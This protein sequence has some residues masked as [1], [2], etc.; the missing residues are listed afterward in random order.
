MNKKQDIKKIYKNI[1]NNKYFYLA[2]IF[3]FILLFNILTPYLYDDFW[4]MYGLKNDNRI[5]NLYDIF[6]NLKTMYLEW[7][8][9]V[10]AHFFAYFFLMLPKWI[11]NIINSLVYTLNIYLI[12][13]IAKGKRKD[14]YL[15]LFLI[16]MLI[17]VFFPVFGQIFLWL[18]GSCNYSFTLCIQLF[19]I[20]KILNIKDNKYNYILYF[21]LSLFAGMCNENSSLSL[22][23]FL[24]LYSIS[25]REYLKL[26][27]TS[28]IGLI[29]G[30]LFMF[31]APGNYVRVEDL[32][33][34]SIFSGL[35][36]KTILLISLFWPIIIALFILIL[37][38]YK[39]NKKEGTLCFII[40]LSSATSFFST[41]ALPAYSNR[42]YTMTVIYIFIIIMIMIFTINNK[43]WKNIILTGITLLFSITLIKTIPEY[44]D[45][46]KFITNRERLINEAVSNNKKELY[47]DTYK[48]GNNCIIP[49]N[50]GLTDISEER[51]FGTINYYMSRYYGIDLYRKD[52]N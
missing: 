3:I 50:C 41:I 31:L 30:Y 9:R 51:Q 34:S 18:D 12:Y 14:N 17:F 8:G 22:I 49:I 24:I 6:I 16:H 48:I 5:K 32:G 36:D 37:I 46:Y 45:F 39:K 11:F 1:I 43:L 42:S 2:I 33:G 27:I 47:I 23:V 35:I 44:I 21:I 40:Y 29:I 15:Y 20:Y 19:F 25:N 38:Y 52:N 7:G 10:L 26:K 28:L 13:L 4:Y